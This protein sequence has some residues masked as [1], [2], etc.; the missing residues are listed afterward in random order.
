MPLTNG[1]RHHQTRK[2]TNTNAIRS[3]SLDLCSTILGLNG[4]PGRCS[5]SQAYRNQPACRSLQMTE[6]WELHCRYFEAGCTDF[7]YLRVIETLVAIVS[8]VISEYEV[9]DCCLRAE[10]KLSGT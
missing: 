5:G 10:E 2:Q 4:K 9:A 8:F 3:R 6:V 1:S 7:S